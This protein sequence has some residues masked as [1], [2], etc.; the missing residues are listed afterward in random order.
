[1][2]TDVNWR[3]RNAVDRSQLSERRAQ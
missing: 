1:V 3:D 2:A